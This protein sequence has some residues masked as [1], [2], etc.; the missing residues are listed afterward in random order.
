ME[1]EAI[2]S[3]IGTPTAYHNFHERSDTV[4]LEGVTHV[5]FG[6]SETSLSQGEQSW[7]SEA[8]RVIWLCDRYRIPFLG[9]GLGMQFL[10][11]TYGASIRRQAAEVGPVQ[12]QVNFHHPLFWF[13]P[14]QIDV[15]T[16]HEESVIDLPSPLLNLGH[17]Q[18]C[19]VQ[20]ICHVK[21]PLFGVQFHPEM[22]QPYINALRKATH[23]KYPQLTQEIAGPARSILAK[24]CQLPTM[25]LRSPSDC[26]PSSV[27]AQ[28]FCVE[29][30]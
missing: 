23:D 30:V 28:P 16:I 9:I 15:N 17:S 2:W 7:F 11:Y 14:D 4:D 6:S 13:L 5:I 18:G 26:F 1:R 20:I 22:N 25:H 29:A 27:A 19:P 24:F 10:A 8:C 21:K 3:H 12:V